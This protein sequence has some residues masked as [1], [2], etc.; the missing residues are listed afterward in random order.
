MLG[1]VVVCTYAFAVVMIVRDD[2]PHGTSHAANSHRDGEVAAPRHETVK[3]A[4]PM[5][6]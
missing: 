5:K 2:T 3:A 4:H 1:D 6:M